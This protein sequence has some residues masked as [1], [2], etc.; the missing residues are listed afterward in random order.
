MNLLMKRTT[1]ARVGGRIA[2]HDECDS[3]MAPRKVKK[4][5]RRL[6][7]AERNRWKKEVR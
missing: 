6:K 5:R 4:M 2:C 1:R 7:R 3:L